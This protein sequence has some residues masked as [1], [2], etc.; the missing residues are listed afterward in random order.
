[1]GPLHPATKDK[2]A[3]VDR[4]QQVAEAKETLVIARRAL[5]EQTQE[6]GQ[7]SCWGLRR[8][9]SGR[10]ITLGPLVSPLHS[11]PYRGGGS[12]RAEKPGHSA[13]RHAVM[14]VGDHTCSD[15]QHWS[16]EGPVTSWLP[17]GGLLSSTRQARCQLPAL[18]GHQLHRHG[19]PGLPAAREDS[20]G[21][22]GA[23]QVR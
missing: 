13:A 7:G 4:P 9:G 11:C 1:M 10:G 3:Q 21:A 2:E 22:A 14:D 12:A 6:G 18:S 19:E 15:S 5:R 16:G 17:P 8:P 20:A 23:A